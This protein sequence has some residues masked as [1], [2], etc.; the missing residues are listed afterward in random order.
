MWQACV[1]LLGRWRG[2]W[3][4]PRVAG[5]PPGRRPRP[6]ARC[7][8]GAARPGLLSPLAGWPDALHARA[9][10]ALRAV[11][12]DHSRPG[13]REARLARPLRQGRLAGWP[14]VV[15]RVPAWLV[16]R[17]APVAVVHL[18]GRRRVLGRGRCTCLLLVLAV[19]AHHQIHLRRRVCLKPGTRHLLEGLDHPGVHPLLDHGLIDVVVL[20]PQVERLASPCTGGGVQLL[21][22]DRRHQEQEALSRNGAVGQV[23][24]GRSALAGEVL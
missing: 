13:L 12:P 20:Q 18:L 11:R 9:D 8:G 14:P 6:V 23:Q 16:G 21:L 2:R 4:G 10:A 15:A 3:H 19:R 17:P 5:A 1:L 22:L 7:A 24:L